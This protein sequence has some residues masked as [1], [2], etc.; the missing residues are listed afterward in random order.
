MRRPGAISRIFANSSA[1]RFC[2][3]A[4][5]LLGRFVLTQPDVNC[6]AQ[7]IVCGPSQISYLGDKLRLDPMKTRQNEWG[8]KWSAAVR[9]SGPMSCGL[10]DPGGGA[11]RRAP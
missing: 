9:R 10:A 6:V 3:L 7:K 4:P 2:S 1:G 8:A 5:H 11:D